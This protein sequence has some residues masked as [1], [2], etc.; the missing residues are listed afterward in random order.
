MKDRGIEVH[1]R[2]AFLQGLL[3]IPQALIPAKFTQW[4]VLWDRWHDWLSR[5]DASPVQ[6]CLA[7][8]LAFPEIDRVVVGADG[9][10]QLKQIISA[11]NGALQ[12]DLPD[13]SC[14]AEDLI[15]P[16]RWKDL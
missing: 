9:V 7:F 13:L 1:T 12:N 3:L 5:H 2:S 8:V 15:N 4:S 14:D 11:A 10:G 16:S 6:A